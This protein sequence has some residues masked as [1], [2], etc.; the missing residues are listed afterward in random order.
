[1]AGLEE[2]FRLDLRKAAFLERLNRFTVKAAAPDGTVLLLHNRNTGKLGDLLQPGAVLYYLEGSKS[3]AK[4][5]SGTLVGVVVTGEDAALIDPYL[6]ARAFEVAWERGLI[7]WLRGWTLHKKEV[8]YGGVRFDYAISSSSGMSGYLELKS[9]VFHDSTG[10]CMYP[11]VPSE[12]G[13]R[14]L[15]MLE[16]I[17]S[18]GMRAVMAFVAAHPLCRSFR[19]CDSCDPDFANL[20]RESRGRGVEVRAVGMALKT[21]G[22]T[23]LT[24]GDLPISLT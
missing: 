1:V 21:D 23:Y 20:L 13:R 4:R 11:D 8:R 2:L 10:N 15:K 17:A 14:H 9:A 3:N 22:S 12:R 5:T 19:P 7:G 24:S 6:Q 16:A 18:Q